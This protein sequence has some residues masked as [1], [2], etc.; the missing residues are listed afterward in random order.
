MKHNALI[1]DFDGTIAD[2][3]MEGVGIYNTMAEEYG[4]LKVE[5]ADLP[6]LRNLSAAGLFRHLGISAHRVPKLLY[7]GT[8]M[9]RGRIANLPLIQGMAETLPKLRSRVSHF[10][11]LTSNSVDN[12]G[13]FLQSHRLDP[14]FTF[15]SSTSKL[16]GKSK[17][18]KSIRKSYNMD[19]SKMLYIGDEIRDIR[20]AKKAGVAVAAVAWGFNSK[21][22]LE[23]EQPDYLLSHPDELDL[24]LG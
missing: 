13:L 6:E 23:A 21:P 20:A 15:V 16:S 22:A 18:L 24:L 3:L 1:F 19:R 5:P 11:I 14:L 12:V 17:H 8:R 7:R 9:L 10:G 2:T 4:L